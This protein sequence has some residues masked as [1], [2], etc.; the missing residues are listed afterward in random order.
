MHPARRQP[1][2]LF[3]KLYCSEIEAIVRRRADASHLLDDTLAQRDSFIHFNHTKTIISGLN[4]RF[5]LAASCLC[6]AERGDVWHAGS[7]PPTPFSRLMSSL[8][9]WQRGAAAERDSGPE[10]RPRT[11]WTTGRSTACLTGWNFQG[12]RPAVG[13]RGASWS[14]ILDPELHSRRITTPKEF[15]EQ[16]SSTGGEESEEGLSAAWKQEDWGCD[17]DE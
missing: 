14:V 4:E 9:S 5:S 8:S 13:P 7:I 16:P 15:W 10:L 17:Y 3:Y 2:A 12:L 1:T 11:V 6:V